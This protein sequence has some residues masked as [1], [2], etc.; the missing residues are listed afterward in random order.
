MNY[1]VL[2]NTTAVTHFIIILGVIAGLLVSFRYRRFRPWEA[3]TLVSVVIL[4]SYYGNCPLTILEQYFRD[5]AGQQAN[6]TS[7]GFLP[8]YAEKLLDI[9]LSSK[10]V[11][12]TTFFTGGALF[13]ASIEWLAPWMHME[14]FKLRK[15]L[16][17]LT[18][19]YSI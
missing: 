8:Y 6:L 3:G 16:R 15:A 5:A 19:H 13:T 4:W 17:K 7:V 18:R 2:A 9:S 1:S 11:Q 14:V 12:H 10:L